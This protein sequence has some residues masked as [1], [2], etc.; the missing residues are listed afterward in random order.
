MRPG[1]LEVRAELLF[2]DLVRLLELPCMRVLLCDLRDLQ[3][4]QLLHIFVNLGVS[5][6]KTYGFRSLLLDRG[7]HLNTVLLV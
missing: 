3:G 4:H 2:S 6:N 5:L 7:W 1:P